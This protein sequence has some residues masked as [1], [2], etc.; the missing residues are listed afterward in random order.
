MLTAE[1]VHDEPAVEFREPVKGKKATLRLNPHNYQLD[2]VP[3]AYNGE[4]HDPL[5][6]R[7]AFYAWGS[8]AGKTTSAILRAAALLWGTQDRIYRWIAPFHR[9]SKIAESRLRKVLP[10]PHFKWVAGDRA[11]IGPKGTVLTFHSGDRPDTIPGEDC[12]G[13]FLD[14]ASRLKEDVFDNTMSTVLSTNGWVMGISTPLGKNWFWKQCVLGMKREA[15]HYYR[16]FP[17]TVNPLFFTSEGRQNLR[18][19]K[20][21]LP[22]VIFRQIVLAEFVAETSSIF[23]SLDPCGSPHLPKTSPSGRKTYMIAVDVGQVVD[24]NVSTVWDVFDGSLVAWWRVRGMD[25][26]GIEANLAALSKKWNDARI[27]VER[28]GPGLGIV[29]HL[30]HN[31][32]N[33][34]KGPDGK[35][36]FQ[37]TGATKPA[38]VHSWGLALR[39]KEPLIPMRD[40]PYGGDSWPSLYEEHEQFEYTITKKGHWQFA[41]P[42]A[43]EAHDDIVMSCILGWWAIG[44]NTTVPRFSRFGDEMLNVPMQRD[45]YVVNE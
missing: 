43:A 24:Y 10:E 33:V 39:N 9:Q 1:Q 25:Y 6:A 14:E 22:D 4:L 35:L 29:Q 2:L 3:Q 13:V 17:T 26:P 12:D 21:S 19:T 23:P 32:Y 38:L 41:A 37:M 31:G 30:A 18:E 36:G 5:P 20:L 11:L 44:A 40:H 16:H 45:R 8:K 15:N 28:N 27:Y 7:F 34:G 42:Q